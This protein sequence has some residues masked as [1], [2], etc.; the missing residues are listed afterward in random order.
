MTLTTLL[1]Y[2]T[3]AALGLTGITYYVLKEKESLWMSF[4][5]NFTGALFLF[6][7]YVKAVDPLG[8]AYGADFS[9]AE[10]V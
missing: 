6:S 1:T 9:G 8:T 4:L 2:I 10:R 7:G 5:Q 3:I